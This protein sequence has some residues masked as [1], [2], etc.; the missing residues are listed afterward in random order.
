MVMFESIRNLTLRSVYEGISAKRASYAARAT[1]AFVFKL[2]GESVYTYQG[3]QMTLTEGCLSYLPKGLSYAVQQ[4]SPGESRYILISFDADLPPIAPQTF[5][6]PNQTA[7]QV[8]FRSMQQRWLFAD[9]ARRHMCYSM[10]YELLSL[11][12][13]GQGK[14]D[15]LARNRQLLAPSIRWLEQHI[16]DPELSVEQM[17]ACSE[18]SETYFRR[19]FVAVYGQSPKQYIQSKRLSQAYAILT[20]GSASSIQAVAAQVGYE[21]PLYFSRVFHRKYGYAPSQ[22]LLETK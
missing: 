15:A 18:I 13:S 5:Q 4:R 10:F 16:F 2:S 21:D 8:F 9:A 3:Q 1:H 11:V 7:M 6:L 22:M 17:I 12:S 20:D 14:D 19:I